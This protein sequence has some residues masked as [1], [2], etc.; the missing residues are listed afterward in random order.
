MTQTGTLF[1]V[2]TPIGNLK[3]ISERAIQT[4][5]SADCIAAEDTRHSGRLLQ[6]FGITT[7]VISLHEHNERERSAEIISWLQQGRD[8]ALITDAGT[9]LLSDPGFY[10][11]HEA[12]KAGISVRLFLEPALQL[13][14]LAPRDYPAIVLSSK[15]FYPLNQKHGVII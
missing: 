9:P 14:H 10:L 15:V 11:V 6:Q 7:R 8:I 12:R 5:Q 2:A 13:P 3:D 4:L 1:V